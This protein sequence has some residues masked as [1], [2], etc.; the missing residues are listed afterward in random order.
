VMRALFML[1]QRPDLEKLTTFIANCRN[2]DGGYGISPG[3]PSAGPP[4]YYASIVLHWVDEMT[5]SASRPGRSQRAVTDRP[6]LRMPN[7]RPLGK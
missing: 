7:P 5:K 6:L 1:K 4:T 3:Q 2:A